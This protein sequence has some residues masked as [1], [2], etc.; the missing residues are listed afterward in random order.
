LL[1]T[2]DALPL[3]LLLLM[4]LRLFGGGERPFVSPFS[5]ETTWFVDFVG[6][7]L[8]FSFGAGEF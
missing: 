1:A 4:L 2:L 6:L 3:L 7:S 8:S 5:C